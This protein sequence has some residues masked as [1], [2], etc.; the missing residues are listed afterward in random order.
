MGKNMKHLIQLT[1]SL[2]SGKTTTASA[3]YGYLIA[4]NGIAPS[5]TFKENG[6]MYLIFDKKTNEGIK[7]DIDDSDPLIVDFLNKNVWK[8]VKHSNLATALKESL[9]MLFGISRE[10]LYGTNEQKNQPTHIMWEDM[11]KLIPE[12]LRAN[13]MGRTGPMSGRN[14]MQI[15]GTEICRTLD[16]DCHIKSSLKLL[17]E[18][19]PIIG[20]MPDGRF[21]NEFEYIDSM[22]PN[23]DFKIWQIKLKK[24]DLKSDMPAEQAAAGIDESRYDLVV[25]NNNMSTLEKNKIVIDFLI[26]NKVLS[27][28][29]IEVS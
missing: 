25:D 20:I 15:W 19:D 10:Y 1:G 28:K 16:S 8:Y 14:L 24:S 21:E 6:D 5:V 26:E 13:Y 18:N 9:I 4:Q 7:L 22:R 17:M 3:I 27:R 2:Q 29:G 12:N 23:V 11:L